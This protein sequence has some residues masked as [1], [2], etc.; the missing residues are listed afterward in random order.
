[1]TTLCVYA[2]GAHTVSIITE[3]GRRYIVE[4]THGIRREHRTLTAAV[5]YALVRRAELRQDSP[6]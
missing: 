2:C 4:D 6:A 3:P 1:M 5:H